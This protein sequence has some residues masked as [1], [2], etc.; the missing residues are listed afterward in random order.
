MFIAETW[1]DGFLNFLFSG[2]QEVIMEAND[3]GFNA[4]MGED[5]GEQR[6]PASSLRSRML[7]SFE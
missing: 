6:R 7:C 2:R 4:F 5:L 3:N 1:F